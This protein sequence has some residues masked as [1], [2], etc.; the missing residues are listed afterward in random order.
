[1]Y[2]KKALTN[3]LLRK[4]LLYFVPPGFSIP[5]ETIQTMSH[6]E[7]SQFPIDDFISKYNNKLGMMIEEQLK[8]GK[9][10]ISQVENAWPAFL[11]FFA[12]M[13][14]CY[15]EIRCT[16][17]TPLQCCPKYVNWSKV[18]V[19]SF[20]WQ[21]LSH[22]RRLVGRLL[23]LV[24]EDSGAGWNLAED[25]DSDEVD[26]HLE[27]CVQSSSSTPLGWCH[28]ESFDW[29]CWRPTRIERINLERPSGQK[30]NAI[31]IA[32]VSIMSP[33]T[34]SPAQSNINSSLLFMLL[35]SLVYHLLFALNHFST[36]RTSFKLIVSHFPIQHKSYW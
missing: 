7:L 22:N 31:C 10:E 25:D 9:S 2:I 26:R 6:K 15:R 5:A 36:P 34:L 19:Q 13:L 18:R 27:L 3:F 29:L 28:F 20:C 33:R 17:W 1:M 4:L 30:Q 23:R 14:K 32:S 35:A 12:R 16:F 11:M 24:N 21:K 8:E